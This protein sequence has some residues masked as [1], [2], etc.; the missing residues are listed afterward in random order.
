ML[1]IKNVLIFSFV[2]INII[3]GFSVSND[4][5]EGAKKAIIQKQKSLIAEQNYQQAFDKSQIL[6][7]ELALFSALFNIVKAKPTITVETAKQIIINFS[8]YK[9]RLSDIGLALYSFEK[10]RIGKN[11]SIGS[12]QFIA[13]SNENKN[14]LRHTFTK[15]QITQE[16]SYQVI[17]NEKQRQY[18]LISQSLDQNSQLILSYQIDL[19]LIQSALSLFQKQE[20]TVMKLTLLAEDKELTSF[21]IGP[22]KNLKSNIKQ[23]LTI[24]KTLSW[25]ISS[26]A[27]VPT[28]S[29]KLNLP[30]SFYLSLIL[31]FISG[32]A[33]FSISYIH[34]R[35]EKQYKQKQGSLFGLE[36][37]YA[38][39]HKQYTSNLVKNLPN[40]LLP[41]LT[42]YLTVPIGRSI[43]Y[44]SSL[45]ERSLSL[46]TQ[47]KS[48]NITRGKILSFF[49]NTVS[50]TRA[51][52]ET[53]F[54]A[55]TLIFNL[56]SMLKYHLEGIPENV[57]LQMQIE[58]IVSLIR[59]K[60]GHKKQKIIITI[61]ADLNIFCQ[62]EPLSFALQQ[63]ILNSVVHGIKDKEKGIVMIEAFAGP[64]PGF[65]TIRIEDNG[66]GISKDKLAAL[67]ENQ[68][69]DKGLGFKISF[70]LIKK[71][72]AGELKIASKERKYTRCTIELPVKESQ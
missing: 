18:L 71:K 64:N 20:M 41:A 19:N 29:Q 17:T 45:E 34:S 31:P 70:S 61:P 30:L 44:I 59:P 37:E 12:A 55:N 4:I 5:K 8:K 49:D 42:E 36:H 46:Q 16:T 58:E 2:I 1:S 53:L 62:P 68:A 32:L 48:G 9:N 66:A 7:K 51:A 33:L 3:V 43:S 72:L 65:F 15:T 38:D 57:N 21:T 22:Y 28:K 56:Q 26:K 10:G 52:N 35:L 39:L 67:L 13:D 40:K 14:N 63:L 24:N 69:D 11:W 47:L 25:Q 60:L 23:E 27:I 54:A 50:L 6:S